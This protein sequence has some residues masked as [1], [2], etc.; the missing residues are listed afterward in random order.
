MRSARSVSEDFKD[1]SVLLTQNSAGVSIPS[2]HVY[3][4]RLIIAPQHCSTVATS[5]CTAK[6]IRSYFRDGVLPKPG[7]V[8]EIETKIFGNNASSLADSLSG[9]EQALVENWR[10]LSESFSVPHFGLMGV[11][12]RGL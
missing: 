12:S 9:E 1:S 5:A 6:A 10:Q 8:C 4:D 2:A 3:D 11:G 7:T